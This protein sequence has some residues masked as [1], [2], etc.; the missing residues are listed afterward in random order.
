MAKIFAT[1]R[2]PDE[3]FK[4]LAHYQIDVFEGDAP[5]SKERIIAGVAG[6]DALICLLTDPI[7]AE[8]MDAAP[9]LRVIANYAVG[10]DNID[11]AEAT[12]RGILV[13][14]TPGVLTETVADLVWSLLMGIARRVAE[15]DRFM[16]KG[17]F[18]GWA[19]LLMLG[20]D[21]Y[22]KTLGIIGA[23]RIGQA[24][25]QRATGFDMHILY[26]SRMPDKQFENSCNARFVNLE[27][28]LQE[29]DYVTLHT[30]LTEETYHLIG[31]KELRLMKPS[32]YLINTARG[33]CIDEQALVHALRE[34]RLRGAALDVFEHEPAVSPELLTLDNVLLAPHMGSASYETRSKMA[35]MVAHNVIAALEGDRPPNCVNP[36]AWDKSER[37]K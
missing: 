36:E 3:G 30:P 11:V 1:R 21:I 7:D 25:A 8:V 24:V 2:I 6:K 33:K 19:P 20:T 15:G 22:G 28:L 35:A 13:T 34:Y 26:H 29:S 17:L 14:N 12:K 5:L 9:N 4:P 18:N 23:G 10:F 37:N 31:E 27:T 32:S 16:R